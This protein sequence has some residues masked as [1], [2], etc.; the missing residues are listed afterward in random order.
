MK[1]LKPSHRE[2]KRY[3]L[4]TGKDATSKNVEESI[5]KFIGILGYAKASPTVVKKL[6]NKLIVS[7]NRKELESIKASISMSGKELSIDKIS[8]TINNLK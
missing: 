2:K 7:I 5:L 6:K 1:A 4:I 3:L 8:G